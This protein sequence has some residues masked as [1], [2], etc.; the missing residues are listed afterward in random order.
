MS[1]KDED[2]IKEAKY[3]SQDDLPYPWFGAVHGIDNYEDAV[4]IS[5]VVAFRTVYTWLSGSKKWDYVVNI[6]FK[7]GFEYKINLNA[8]GYD[9]FIEHFNQ[10]YS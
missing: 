5:E 1:E 10:V 4:N 8:D 3:N 6:L 9:D 7:S 2:N